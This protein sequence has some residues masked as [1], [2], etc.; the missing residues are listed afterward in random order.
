MFNNWFTKLQLAFLE[1]Y[2]PAAGQPWDRGLGQQAKGAEHVSHQGWPF[3]GAKEV[4]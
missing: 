4:F 2:K 3:Q 1:H